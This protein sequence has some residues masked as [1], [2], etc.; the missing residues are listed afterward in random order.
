MRATGPSSA[1]IQHLKALGVKIRLPKKVPSPDV[2]RKTS[3]HGLFGTPLHCLPPCNTEGNIPQFVVDTCQFLSCHLGTEGLFRKSGSVTRIRTLK[4]QLESNECSLESAQPSDVAA[5]LK[6]FFRELPQPLIPLELQDPLCQ[7]H[8]ILSEES[9]VSATILVTC[10][11][12]AIH[13]GTLRYFCTFLQSVASRCNE[14]RM[15]SANLAV[16]LAPNLFASTGLGERLTHSTERQLQLQTAVM[17]TLIQNAS[18]IGQLPSFILSKIPLA[19]DAV[20][21][22]LVTPSGGVNR[23]RRRRSMSGLVNEALSKL[24]PGRGAS[25]NVL[26]QATGEEGQHERYKS[27]RKAS[28]DS[29]SGEHCTAK[30]RKSLRDITDEK[31]YNEDLCE[32]VNSVSPQRVFVDASPDLLSSPSTPLELSTGSPAILA[33]PESSSR[34]QRVKGKRKESKRP[35][36]MHSG[37]ICVS[38]AQLERKEK[39]RSSMRLF[40]RMRVSKQSTLDG[41]NL[42]TSGWNLMK[43]M[44]A[45]ALE[46]PIFNGRDFRVAPLSLKVSGQE[47]PLISEDVSHKH[48]SSPPCLS[49]PPFWKPTGRGRKGS[50]A[51]SSAKLKR[52]LRRSLSMPEKLGEGAVAEQGEENS[53]HNEDAF[54]RDQDGISEIRVEESSEVKTKVEGLNGEID[55]LSPN[56]LSRDSIVSKEDFSI[57]R[58]AS[59][60]DLHQK[61]QSLRRAEGHTA[62]Y[63][64]VRKLVLSF[65][66][67]THTI[68]NDPHQKDWEA[69]ATHPIK[70]KGARRFGRSISHES[71]LGST[72]EQNGQISGPAPSAK[73]PAKSL[74]GRSRQV[75]VS[76]KS[77]TLSSC[78][79]KSLETA[80]PLCL[81]ASVVDP[82]GHSFIKTW[83]L[84]LVQQMMDEDKQAYRSSPKYP[85]S[86]T[87]LEPISDF[88]DF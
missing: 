4:A 62:Q 59:V 44:V 65:P 35:K 3:S 27:K 10:L 25:T 8:E 60:S 64:S 72:E 50:E 61:S 58:Q 49:S 43:R 15:D 85:L 1:I 53:N 30:K 46:G 28:E 24:K 13:M 17:Q 82:A 88:I 66:W 55:F 78:V 51:A 40:H 37:H 12:P 29:G 33:T 41:K 36:R 18:N 73:S 14:N 80:K 42:E 20:E 68:N 22:E 63:R 79:Q 31:L 9:R 5:L 86:A 23:R 34:G 83:D 81:D 6:Q 7:I 45:E 52:A 47:N 84:S 11:L 57:H 16:V 38:P 77:I 74:K 87:R 21:E 70:R 54:T 75:F 71:G 69:L 56:K 67:D 2:Q 26:D 76:R 39:V 19:H 48:P 32:P